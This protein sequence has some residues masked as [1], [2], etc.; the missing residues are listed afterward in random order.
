[1][2][3]RT[4]TGNDVIY[5]CEHVLNLFGGKNR[6]DI[7]HFVIDIISFINRDAEKC[8]DDA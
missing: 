5:R 7:I 2:P 1:M 4:M 3:K 6:I 8:Q